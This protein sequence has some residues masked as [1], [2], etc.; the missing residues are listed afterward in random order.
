MKFLDSPEIDKN[1]D[2]Q[3]VDG[4]IRKIKPAQKSNSTKIETETLT[5]LNLSCYSFMQEHDIIP[6]LPTLNPD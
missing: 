3:N 1:I 4:L 5:F 2:L 6:V